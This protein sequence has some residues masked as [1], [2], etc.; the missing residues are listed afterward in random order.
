MPSWL[1]PPAGRSKIVA[2]LLVGIAAAAAFGGRARADVAVAPSPAAERR[3]VLRGTSAHA[4][5][6]P[7]ARVVMVELGDYECPFCRDYHDHVF[8]Q[9]RADYVETGRVRYEARD[10]P[11]AMHEHA[12]A[13]AEAARCAGAQGRF[14]PMRERLIAESRALTFEGLAP[15]ARSAGLAVAPFEA[16]RAAHT[17]LPAIHED[18]AAAAAAGLDRTPSF[19]IGRP[20][21]GGISGL[22]IVGTK[23]YAFFREKLERVLRER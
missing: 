5:G 6:S 20:V 14:W 16:C 21:A 19:V 7:R 12:L 2:T 13:A 22:V 9:I 17:F 11:L 4:L 8:S 3:V 23:P 1:S 18:M 15:L 10:L